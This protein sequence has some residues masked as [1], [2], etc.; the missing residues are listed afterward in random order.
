MKIPFYP[1]PPKMELRFGVKRN[2]LTQ[3]FLLQHHALH[4]KGLFCEIP[5]SSVM[6]C[7]T[8]S[9]LDSSP[10]RSHCYRP[11]RSCG[12]GNI[13]TRVCHSFCSRG[14]VCL[15]R[16][17]GVCLSACWDTTPRGAD[18]PPG[19]G[20]PTHLPPRPGRP[21][22]PPPPRSRHH[23]PPQTRQTPRTRQTN[24]SPQSRHHHPPDQ[25]DPPGKQTS[26]YS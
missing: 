1:P 17:E 18:T 23:H 7:R 4:H 25:A 15:V 20:R 26:A 12:Q 16:G 22:H 10:S 6:R 9:R 19:P 11:Q 5:K 24:P 14:V 21:T 8:I 2:F 13:F 3:N